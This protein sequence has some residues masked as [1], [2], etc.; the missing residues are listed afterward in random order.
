MKRTSTEKFDCCYK[1]YRDAQKN[2]CDC[3]KDKYQEGI[4]FWRKEKNKYWALC[5]KYAGM[6]D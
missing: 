1:A 5:E 6:E 3:I 2:L 4:D